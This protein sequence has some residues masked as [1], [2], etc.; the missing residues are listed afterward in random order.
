MA[1]RVA[2]LKGLRI[3]GFTGSSGGLLASLATICIRVPA[4]QTHLVQEYHLPIYHCLCAMLEE[5][6]FPPTEAG[7]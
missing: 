7:H 4:T 5:A 1:C 2:L 6:F 3:V